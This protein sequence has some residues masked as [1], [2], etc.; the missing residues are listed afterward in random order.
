MKHYVFFARTIKN[1]GG[2]QLYIKAKAQWLIEQGWNV[3]II[4]CQD[5]EPYIFDFQK[6]RSLYVADL[7]KA[8]YKYLSLKRKRIVRQIVEFLK[9]QQGDIVFESHSLALASWAE[10]IAQMKGN[11]RHIAFLLDE[12]IHVPLQMLD[13]FRFK[14]ARHEL[15]GITEKSIELFFEGTQTELS[16]GSPKLS[17]T[18]VTDCVSDN[19]PPFKLSMLR[20]TII[21]VVGR[22]EKPYVKEY[23]KSLKRY[24]ILHN[25][26]CFTLIFVGGAPKGSEIPA[27]LETLFLNCPNVKLVITGYLFP[28]PRVLVRRFDICL[29]G[30]GAANAIKR[31]GVATLVLDPRDLMPNGILG[32]TTQDSLF[33]DKEKKPIDWWLDEVLTHKERYSQPPTSLNYDFSP[34]MEIIKNGEGTCEYNYSFLHS[35]SMM[36]YIKQIVCSI[37]PIKV[38]GYFALILR[39]LSILQEV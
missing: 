21:G 35:S 19:M 6:Y 15:F 14:Y 36:F 33:S 25:N 31:E 20:G 26:T 37:F 30:A 8:A 18:G 12:R 39:H 27:Q 28:I 11:V 34:H 16:Y 38:S 5:G 3:I 29:A 24:F 4:Y 2:A 22:L 32:V 7:C 9:F 13:Y 17:A 23:A 10:L 1:V